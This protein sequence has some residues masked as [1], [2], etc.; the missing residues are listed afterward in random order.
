MLV[1]SK[2]W[3][4][5]FRRIRRCVRFV[6]SIEL[7]FLSVVQGRKAYADQGIA[8]LDASRRLMTSCRHMFKTL[9]T[10]GRMVAPVT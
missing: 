6:D 8:M 10:I 9:A 4:Q 1:R 5:R 2:Y 3:L 7:A